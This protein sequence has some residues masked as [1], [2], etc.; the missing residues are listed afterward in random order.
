MANLTS[1][2]LLDLSYN[3][4]NGNIVQSPLSSL[5]SL[6]YLS[7]SYNNFSIPSTLSFL[8]NLSNL[9]I[10][11]SDNNIIALEPDSLTWIPTVQL[12]VLSLSTC[13]FNIHNS[14]PPRFLH[15]QNDLRVIN[16]YQNKLVRQFP[17][18]L[19]ENNTRLENFIVNNNSFTGSFMVPYDIRPNMLSIDISDNYLH[20]PIPT[21]LGLIFPNLESLKMSRN[22]F[23]GNIPS[24]FGNLVF[25]LSLDLSENHFSRAIPMHFIMGCYNL[26]LLTLSNNNFSGQI[27]PTY[28]NW[29]HLGHLHLENNHFL[30]TLPTWI[31]NVTYIE[32]IVMAKILA[33]TISC[34]NNG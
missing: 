6:E 2:H 14:T 21:N 11:L 27:F 34:N 7:F 8:S 26:E 25:L 1:L 22:E 23:E 28:S 33:I 4:F 19:L 17:Y 18:W 15:Y 12:K 24:S 29:T 10:L 9:K 5:T 32:D 30:G 13:S 31:G 20:G 3:H 16:L